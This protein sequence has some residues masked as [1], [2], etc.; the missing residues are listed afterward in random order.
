MGTGNFRRD[1][2]GQ[3]LLDPNNAHETEAL[4]SGRGLAGFVLDVVAD[5]V[6]LIPMASIAK[7]IGRFG[8]SGVRHLGKAADATQI[9]KKGK[10]AIVDGFKEMFIP[11]KFTEPASRAAI[12]A[13]K[14]IDAY[15]NE[16]REVIIDDQLSGN[17]AWSQLAEEAGMSPSEL[18]LF[19]HETARLSKINDP[20]LLPEALNDTF[21]RIYRDYGVD[22]FDDFLRT[23]G[24]RA[25]VDEQPLRQA[26][27]NSKFDDANQAM[28]NAMGPRASD[29]LKQVIF[30]LKE[31]DLERFV[32]QRSKE[33]TTTGALS[34]VMESMTKDYM[35]IAATRAFREWASSVGIKGASGEAATSAA[36]FSP[37]TV[38][39]LHSQL[40]EIGA[41][42]ANKLLRTESKQFPGLSEFVVR[43]PKTGEPIRA[44]LMDAGF[45]TDPRLLDATKEYY[46][47]LAVNRSQVLG[48]LVEGYGRQ[49]D[50][51]MEVKVMNK[52]TGLQAVDSHGNPITKV[53]RTFKEGPEFVNP[54]AVA[55]RTPQKITGKFGSKLT[56]A[57]TTV[58]L[59]DEAAFELESEGLRILHDIPGFE[60]AALPVEAAKIVQD[61]EKWASASFDSVP[62]VKAYSDL[63][64]KVWKPMTLFLFPGYFSR[65]TLTNAILQN[66][67]G[68]NPKEI[69][70]YTAR[71]AK[72][73]ASGSHPN[74]Y[75]RAKE[76]VTNVAG[77]GTGL[78]HRDLFSQATAHPSIVTRGIAEPSL[79]EKATSLKQLV[80]GVTYD[81]L[82]NK[83]ELGLLQLFTDL[84]VVRSGQYGQG[85]VMR[86]LEDALA[87]SR[88]SPARRIA[89]NLTVDS[90]AVLSSGANTAM[91]L[92][93]SQRVGAMLW[94]LEQGEDI[95]KGRDIVMRG[96]VDFNAMTDFEKNVVRKYFMPFYSWARHATPLAMESFVMDNGK[97]RAMNKI[98]EQQ[99]KRMTE[100][101][102][103]LQDRM[104]PEYIAR[105]LNIPV[106][107]SESGEY[108]FMVLDGW[109]PMSQLTDIDSWE[110]LK[111]FLPSQLG[112]IPKT[113]M[114]LMFGESLFLEREFSRGN[115]TFLGQRIP[116]ELITVL[117]NLRVLNTIDGFMKAEGSD[118]VM[119]QLGRYL[120]G[121]NVVRVEGGKA[122]LAYKSRLTEA[123]QKLTGDILNAAREGATDELPGLIEDYQNLIK[124]GRR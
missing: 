29:D 47:S 60:N 92:E 124:K 112:P 85:E 23:S 111:E 86:N 79:A 93:D 123:R 97:W 110:E 65:N 11:K 69:V 78:R 3:D 13:R 91:L 18:D 55:A 105:G 25:V 89:G 94:M 122:A 99:E 1:I 106:A 44:P 28:V 103:T 84:G 87:F 59:T 90:S 64:N 101:E 24:Y 104:V 62:L 100:G 108:Q 50:E 17:R 36:G 114:E 52:S 95:L 121:L 26:I 38:S 48:D 117:R 6:N 75:R 30:D 118:E 37:W 63:Q 19:V 20:A 74:Y 7:M 107:R 76:A 66:K 113:T 21:A 12:E 22:S 46:A 115:R 72:I 68:M 4:F 109:I 120:T 14:R 116:D 98:I 33:V 16:M 43:H 40:Q 45:H 73:L 34:P 70:S 67:I 39:N 51:F 119:Q 35:M 61:T 71:G 15:G 2:T 57:G 9:T 31:R 80:D 77:R 8:A 54:L 53:V 81:Q 58:R 5:P 102:Q 42:G 82:P 10:D 32:W 56:D 96:M 88:K 49:L 27:F 83:D 41:E